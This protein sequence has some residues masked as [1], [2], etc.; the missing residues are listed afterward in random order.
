MLLRIR[1]DKTARAGVRVTQRYCNIACTWCHHD[2]FDHNGF[3][4]IGNTAFSTAVERVAKASSATE[5]HVRLAGDGDPT[6]VGANELADLVL[7]LKEVPTV[8]K[9]KITTNG[10]LLGG[11]AEILQNAGIDTVTIS[12]NTLSRNEYIRYAQYDY[13]DQV[14]TSIDKASSCGVHLKINTIYWKHNEHEI[15]DF[16]AL[17]VRYNGMAIKFFDLLVHSEEDREYYRPLSQLENKLL[18]RGATFTQEMWPYPKRVYKLS[19]GATFDVKIAG[20]LNNCPNMNCRVRE[21]CLEGCRHSVRIGLDG[22]MRPC[23]VRTDNII[24]LFDPSVEDSDIWRALHSGGKVGY[25]R[26]IPIN[27]IG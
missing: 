25:D 3:V 14:L 22:I 1:L 16:E 5:T 2:Y 6:I 15:D 27:Q 13:L 26:V 11:M 7:R 21:I 19:S 24:D 12:L 23:G 4:A 10:V 18:E 9:V 17:S 20:Q 8:T